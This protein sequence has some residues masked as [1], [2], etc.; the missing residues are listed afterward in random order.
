MRHLKQIILFAV[1]VVATGCVII[2]SCNDDKPFPIPDTHDTRFDDSTGIRITDTVTVYFGD[3]T[4]QT[5]FYE[6]TIEEDSMSIYRWANITAHANGASYPK[7]KLR[8]LLEPVNHTA[9]MA[10]NDPGIG[11][12]IPG[13][14]TGD[15]KC[16]SVFYYEDK[17]L[18][19]PDGTYS[20]DWWPWNITLSVLDYDRKEELLTA[21]VIA[22]MFDYESWML[23]EVSDVDSA[24]HREL[25]IAFGNMQL[26]TPE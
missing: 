22:T 11:Y 18:H 17:E 4:W 5:L 21:R 7:F 20:S 14:L 1:I 8:I 19:S 24:E 15:I 13:R 2:T 25:I 6:A 12:T 9:H 10:V 23:R 3:T 16:G 26:T